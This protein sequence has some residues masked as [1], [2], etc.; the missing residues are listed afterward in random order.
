MDVLTNR[1]TS[2]ATKRLPLTYEIDAKYKRLNHEKWY[3]AANYPSDHQI[4]FVSDITLDGDDV[5][6]AYG[7][8]DA[9]SRV[10]IIAVNDLDF[11]FQP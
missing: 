6:I 10:F 4:A 3:Y 2:A 1:V 11:Y 7:A 8:G 9:E 5:I